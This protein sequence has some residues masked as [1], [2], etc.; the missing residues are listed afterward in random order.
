M[1][2]Y[3]RGERSNGGRV[4]SGTSRQIE[5]NSERKHISKLTF[6]LSAFPCFLP[7]CQLTKSQKAEK[8]KS[9]L[10]LEYNLVLNCSAF[11]AFLSFSCFFRGP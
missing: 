11:L 8:Y 4:G 2:C 7:C 3:T 9:R 10:L 5:R 1:L 6:Y